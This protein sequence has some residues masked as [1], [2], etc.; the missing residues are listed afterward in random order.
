MRMEEKLARDVY[1]TLEK[2][3]KHKM[4]VNITESEQRHMDAVR[5]LLDKYEIP[6]PVTDH[7]IGVFTKDEFKKLYD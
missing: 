2:T 5:A 1:L 6:D 4:F 3:Y 7:K